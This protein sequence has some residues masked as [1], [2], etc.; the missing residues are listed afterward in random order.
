MKKE[1]ITFASWIINILNAMR[2]AKN[3]HCIMPSEAESNR[4]LIERVCAI[5]NEATAKLEAE[6]EKL[7]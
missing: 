1:N 7:D 3:N 4:P 5:V 6:I 2:K